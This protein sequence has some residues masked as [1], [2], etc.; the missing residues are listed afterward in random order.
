[1][2]LSRLRIKAAKEME[3]TELPKYVLV[4]RF[5]EYYIRLGKHTLAISQSQEDAERII[6]A[7]NHEC[8]K[9]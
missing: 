3:V 1:M 4:D 2:G 6:D 5:G 9:R 7:L 8:Q